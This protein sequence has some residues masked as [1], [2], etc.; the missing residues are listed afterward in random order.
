MST[1]V[2]YLFAFLMVIGGLM[3]ITSKNPVHSVLYLIFCFFNASGLFIMI[4]AEFVAMALVIVYVG[5]VAV[6]FLF[7]VM[8]MNIK[9][10]EV[11]QGFLK[12]LPLGIFLGALV[13]AQIFYSISI[14]LDSLPEGSKEISQFTNTVQ[15]GRVL[16]TDYFLIFQLAGIVLFVA[17]IGAILLT[18]T[19][20]KKVKRQDISKQILRSKV[21][22]LKLV[23]VKFGEG[24]KL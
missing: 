10:A 20:S 7:V 3:V 23:D 12:T 4:G 9:V 16:Y 14:S 24:I 18:L 8:M 11:K 22:T 17:M 13:F 1:L 19:H 15:I 5:A 6:L 2:F 21:D